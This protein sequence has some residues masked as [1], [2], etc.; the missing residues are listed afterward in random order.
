MDQ[1]RAG[2]MIGVLVFAIAFLWSDV[3]TPQLRKYQGQSQGS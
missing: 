2:V 1:F 3:V